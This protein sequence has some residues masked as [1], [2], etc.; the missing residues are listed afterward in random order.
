VRR[1]GLD[2]IIFQIKG[3]CLAIEAIVLL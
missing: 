1:C 3:W 2:Q